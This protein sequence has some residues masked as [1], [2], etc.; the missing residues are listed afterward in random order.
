[1]CSGFCPRLVQNVKKLQL[2]FGTDPQVKVIF[3]SVTPLKDTPS[4]LKEYAQKMDI[5]SPHWHFLTGAKE[6]IYHLARDI[7]QADTKT[8]VQ[9]GSNEFVHSENIYLMDHHLRFRGIYNGNSAAAM[10]D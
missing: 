4:L 9:Q 8:D 3:H 2:A 7:Y 1:S 5:S 10:Q 6:T